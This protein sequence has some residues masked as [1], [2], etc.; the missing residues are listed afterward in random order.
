MLSPHSA[1]VEIQ[2]P[3]KK[4][5]RSTPMEILIPQGSL[6]ESDQEALALSH[7]LE[8]TAH[9][10][11]AQHGH[12]ISIHSSRWESVIGARYGRI[13]RALKERGVEI[14][15]HYS[16]GRFPMSYRLSS[17]FRVPH[18]EHF[19]L[20]RRR[21][22]SSSI[23][24]NSDDT[25]GMGLV[26]RL[27][28]L[29]LPTGVD[30]RGWNQFAAFA[31][32]TGRLYACRCQ[33]G[34]FHSPITGLSRE[35][36]DRLT[37]DLDEPVLE[38]DISN[39]QPLLLGLMAVAHTEGHLPLPVEG[40]PPL[41]SYER[42]AFSLRRSSTHTQPPPHSICTGVSATL[43]RYLELCQSGELYDSLLSHCAGMSL[44][45]FIVPEVRHRYAE[46]RPV[47]R[48]LVKRGFLV[49]LFSE[50]TATQR[51]PLFQ[52]VEREF[53]EIARFIL[54]AKQH[55]FQELARDCQRFESRIMIDGVSR[56]LMERYPKVAFATVHD[57]ILIPATVRTVCE[58]LIR[59]QFSQFGVTPHLKVAGPTTRN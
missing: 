34:R 43:R 13:L 27:K 26:E 39:C 49:M 9:S 4:R 17:Q 31:L 45:D 10:D 37:T 55:C 12:W 40:P 20:S 19:R 24:I 57:S 36:R 1:L 6:P 15:D 52:V 2:P 32:F 56:Q 38:V 18:F 21:S 44:F 30:V 51:L 42:R 11:D 23:R 53:P 47:D 7:L 59:E 46:D 14:N 5:V 22:S 33:Y 50:Y 35:L 25:V 29:R 16:K 48:D 8:R 58:C 41:L 28:R 3:K 54:Q